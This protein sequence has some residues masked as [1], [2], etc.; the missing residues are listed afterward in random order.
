VLVA[1]QSKY[2]VILARTVLIQSESVTDGQTN[3]HLDDG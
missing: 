1:A 2:F 3:E